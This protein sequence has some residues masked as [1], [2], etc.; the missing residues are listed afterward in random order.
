[1]LCHKCQNE[2]AT[3]A[4]IGR[5]D[6]CDACGA[7]LHVCLNCGFYDVSAY[8]DCHEPTAERVVDK[9]RSNF[10]EYFMPRI[11]MRAGLEPAPTKITNPAEEAKRKLAELFKKS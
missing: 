5:R 6:A 4:K 8:N 2:I 9:E 3:T 1:M 11:Q 7:D 10:C